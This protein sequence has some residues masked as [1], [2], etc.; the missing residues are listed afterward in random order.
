MTL[1][2]CSFDSKPRDALVKQE[3][4]DKTAP[5]GQSGCTAV[6]AVTRDQSDRPSEVGV[7]VEM[8]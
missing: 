6:V 4:G 8:V 1:G 3:N 5:V 7:R 2:I